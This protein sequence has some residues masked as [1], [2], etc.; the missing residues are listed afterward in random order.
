MDKILSTSSYGICLFS[1]EVVQDFLKRNAGR[2]K[3]F[4]Y[5]LQ[6][7][8]ELYLDSQ[9]EGIWVPIVQINNVNYLIKLDGYDEPFNDEWEQLLEYEG[10]N[11]EVRNGLWVSS[12]ESL[13]TFNAGE[14]TGNERSART[15]DGEIYF[16]DLK[17]DVPSGKY[18]LSI[19]GYARREEQ[20]YPVPNCGYFFSLERVEAFEGFK[21]PRENELYEFN[22]G[23]LASSKK[24]TVYWLPDVK[25][26]RSKRNTNEYC[27]VIQMEDGELCWLSIVFG[28]DADLDKTEENCRVDFLIHYEKFKDLLHSGAEYTIYNELRKRGKTVL[29][30]VG[31]IV[32]A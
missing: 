26:R 10:F 25:N 18:L 12:T 16:T 17:Y 31:R 13:Y 14:F 32:I 19:K 7:D 29:E 15:G 20:K 28:M 2:K 9:K 22:I 24:A 3:K 6:K 8:R 23:W 21:N 5:L 27:P 11:I 4:V 30:E 1:V